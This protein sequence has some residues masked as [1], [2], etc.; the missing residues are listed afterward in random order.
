MKTKFL[1]ICLLL[2][3]SQVFADGIKVKTSIKDIVFKKMYCECNNRVH[4][5]GNNCLWMGYM[6]NKGK[7][8]WS[9][10]VKITSYDEDGDI[11]G[12]SKTHEYISAKKGVVFIELGGPSNCDI[13]STLRI[14]LITE[15]FTP[16]ILYGK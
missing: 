13:S 6:V 9:G 1:T 16:D 5:L 7:N 3:T 2:F 4:G 8:V 14:K 11:M 12:S 15:L 10:K